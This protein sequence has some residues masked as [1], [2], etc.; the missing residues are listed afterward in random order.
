MPILLA[1]RFSA[2]AFNLARSKGVVTATPGILFGSDVAKGLSALLET[3]NHASE[4]AAE[5]PEV[6]VDLFDRLGKIEGAAVNLRGALFE[7]IVGHVVHLESQGSIDIGKLVF[8]IEKHPAEID[9]FLASNVQVRVI[10]C[11]GYGPDQAVK[12]DELRAWVVEKVP[13][14]RKSLLSEARF[15]NCEFSF[16]F[17]TS[18]SFTAEALRLAKETIQR[19]KKYKIQFLNGVEVRKRIRGVNASGLGKVFDEHYAKQPLTRFRGK[20]LPTEAGTASVDA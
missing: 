19:T 5:N 13:D 10:E 2:E 15:R 16:E 1:G 11:K 9:V 7:L 3:L 8:L 4:V 20:H 12:E 14:L 6:V 17:W 18:G